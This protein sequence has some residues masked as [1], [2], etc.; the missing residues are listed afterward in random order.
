MRRVSGTPRTFESSVA[1]ED[2]SVFFSVA[3]LYLCVYTTVQRRQLLYPLVY[4]VT[5]MQV[6]YWLSFYLRGEGSALSYL[7]GYRFIHL[8]FFPNFLA[9]AV[10]TGYLGLASN[11]KFALLNID[12]NF[13]RNAGETLCLWFLLGLVTAFHLIAEFFNFQLVKDIY[14]KLYSV[15]QIL[16]MISWGNA[17]FFGFADFYATVNQPAA[18]TLFFAQINFAWAIIIFG[19]LSLMPFGVLAVRWY[20][21]RNSEKLEINFILLQFMEYVKRLVFGFVII[22]TTGYGNAVL[23]GV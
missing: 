16:F 6:L 9:Y 11:E 13:I 23:P 7:V 10:P 19:L 3:M 14:N 1:V 5:F 8:K 15:L 2:M 20:F 12:N 17:F 18:R 21:T 22:A 4:V